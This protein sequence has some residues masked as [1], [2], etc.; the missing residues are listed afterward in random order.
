M[1]IHAEKRTD[2]CLNVSQVLDIIRDLSHS[3]GF[4]QRLYDNIMNLEEEAFRDFKEVMEAQN[5]KDPVDVIMFF[6]V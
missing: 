1:L 2:G 4:Y 3:Q 6:E 5:F